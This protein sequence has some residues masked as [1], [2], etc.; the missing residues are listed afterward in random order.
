MTMTI[1]VRLDDDFHR[2]PSVAQCFPLSDMLVR[3]TF[4]P[5][6]YPR[7]GAAP[8]QNFFCTRPEKIEMTE[9]MR[10]ALAVE[11]STILTKAILDQMGARDMQCGYQKE[12][13]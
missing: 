7:P 11:I 4:E 2:F 1:S 9:N 10:A 12:V 3:K 5:L 13:Q 8:S 6:D